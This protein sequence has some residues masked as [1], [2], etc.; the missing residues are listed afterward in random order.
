MNL[1]PDYTSSDAPHAFP[2]V[3]TAIVLDSFLRKCEMNTARNIRTMPSNFDV[4]FKAR[5]EINEKEL[6]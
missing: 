5:L 4:N 6:N 3:H 1:N 2:D